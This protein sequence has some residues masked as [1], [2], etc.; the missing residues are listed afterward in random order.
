[1]LFILWLRLHCDKSL[2]GKDKSPGLKDNS[3]LLQVVLRGK[4]G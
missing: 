4:K 2:V 1:M 3:K